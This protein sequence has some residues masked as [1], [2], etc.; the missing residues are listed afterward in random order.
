VVGFFDNFM[1][2]IQD[3]SKV[4]ADDLR[5][6]AVALGAKQKWA[7]QPQQNGQPLSQT[8][9]NTY[10]RGVKSFWKWLYDQRI[11]QTNPLAEVKAP[12]LPRRLPKTLT[13]EELN[14]VIEVV[15]NNGRNRALV[16]TLLDSGMR[17][18]EL[19]NLKVDDF[20]QRDGSIR[21][22]GKGSRERIVYVSSA[23]LLSIQ[24]YLVF[25]RPEPRLDDRLFLTHDGY[26]LTPRRVQ[27]ILSDI[28]KK[29][30]ISKRLSPHKL[31]HSFATL[32]LKNGANLEYVRRV[33]GHTD[34]KT[35]EIYLGVADADVQAAFR[36]F[37]PVSNLR[38]K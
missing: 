37:S 8:S 27:K 18:S 23:T 6:F 38:K 12:K 35:T 7:G 13:E 34:V 32:S 1:G 14:K 4:K 17:L 21:V 10:I 24:T 33:L 15:K 5:A 9:I 29:A 19:C 31:R 22:F 25:D 26:P 28:G 2:S 11:I 16:E 20:N 3:A 30:G 36:K